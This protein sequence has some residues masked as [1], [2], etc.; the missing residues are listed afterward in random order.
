MDQRTWRVKVDQARDRL[1]Y[2]WIGALVAGAFTIVMLLWVSIDT[3]E[4]ML[5]LP[6]LGMAALTIGLGYGTFRGSRLAAGAQLVTFVA[7]MLLRWLETGRPGPLLII[8]ILAYVYVQGFRG[9][10]DL[11]ALRQNE[12]PPESPASAR[13]EAASSRPAV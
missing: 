12:P 4:W 5:A 3:G 11:A 10:M 13:A 6:F 2:A 8:A 1:Y 9:A 7:G